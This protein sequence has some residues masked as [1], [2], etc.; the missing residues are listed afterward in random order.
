[1]LSIKVKLL[2]AF[3][4]II[5]IM[6][7]SEAFFVVMH[8]VVVK[9]YQEIT[10]N[11]VSEYQLIETTGNL[12]NSFYDLIQYSEDQQ[13]M[14]NYLYNLSTLRSLLSKL[15]NSITDIESQTVYLGVKNTINGVIDETSQGVS[16][17][18]IG[19]FS[20]VTSFYKEANQDNNFVRENTT[21]LLLKELGYIEKLQGD[22]ARTQALSEI[23]GISLFILMFIGCLWYSLFFSQSLISPLLKLTR[24]AKVIGSGNLRADVENDL[25]R[26]DD[27]VASLAHSFN[28]M[29]FSLKENIRKLK[30]K[31]NQLIKT[32]KIIVSKESKISELNEIS[33]LKD[34][35][36]NIVTHELKTPLI[37][38]IGLAEVM[39]K[40]KETLPPDYQDYVITIHEEGIKLSNLIKQMLQATRSENGENPIAKEKF[41]LDELI[42]SLETSLSMLARRT[43]S[44][45]VFN[46]RDRGI[47]MDS[48]KEKIS[49]IIYNFVDNAVKYGPNS[50]NIL[51]TVFKPDKD[52]V[53]I[54]VND[55]G[56]GIPKDLHDKLFLK[57]SQLEPSLSRSREGMG[58]GLY[59]CKRNVDVLGGKIGVESESGQ[60]ATFYFTIPLIASDNKKKETVP[61]S[62]LINFFMSL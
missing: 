28:A 2:T 26:G 35:F 32:Q 15:D 53:R 30:E 25:L 57:F 3:L 47:E 62:K 38:I 19:N 43:D 16:S 39:E 55:E 42:T 5:A 23:I 52:N 51:I 31:N 4:T 8:F 11:M 20:E 33:R 24:L 27:E 50:Q 13:R 6:F 7:I 17:I 59:I 60:G 41:R 46:F 54:E 48:D 10:D 9:R 56:P 37:P 36:M 40:R 14:N 12:V 21:N 22:I 1:M 49:Q 44:K 61:K 18:S 58:L 29:V 34:E 45:V